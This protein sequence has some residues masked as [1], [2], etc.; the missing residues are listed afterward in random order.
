MGEILYARKAEGFEKKA[1]KDRNKKKG[2]RFLKRTVRHEQTK[3]KVE[4]NAPKKITPR[5]RGA[6]RRNGQKVEKKKGER[7][8]NEK[9]TGHAKSSG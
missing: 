6:R 2:V 3:I 9:K 5:G 7:W 1:W 8:G 4:R